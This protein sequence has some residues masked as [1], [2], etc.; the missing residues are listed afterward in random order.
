VFRIGYVSETV[1]PRVR[2][3]AYL[4]AAVFVPIAPKQS[5]RVL[6]NAGASLDRRDLADEL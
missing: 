5:P 6:A 3:P 2:T 4:A 1:M